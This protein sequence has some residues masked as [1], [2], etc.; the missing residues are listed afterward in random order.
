MKI[1]QNI[2]I[3]LT[4]KTKVTNKKDTKTTTFFFNIG[5]RNNVDPSIS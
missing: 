2:K 5:E 4:L 1:G 3:I